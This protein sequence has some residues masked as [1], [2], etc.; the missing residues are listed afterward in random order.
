LDE[1]RYHGLLLRAPELTAAENFYVRKMGLAATS[2]TAGWTRLEDD[3]GHRLYMERVL[4]GPAPAPDQARATV[5]FRVHDIEAAG[6]VFGAA[7]PMPTRQGLCLRIRDPFGNVLS[8]LQPREAAPFREP[9]IHA[10][11]IKIPIAS[12]PGARRLYA[13]TLDFVV[14]DERAYPPLM[15]LCHRDGSPAFTIEDKEIWEP[16]LRVRAPLYPDE[17]GMVLVL[18]TCHAAAQ[19]ERLTRRAPNLKLTPVAEFPLGLRLSFTGI[20]GLAT[21]IWQLAAK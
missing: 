1:L 14:Q 15:A 8:L 9:L 16:D 2:L 21:E 13:D 17:T 7:V 10:A 5:T 3:G 6:R 18:Q 12:V 20:A 19:H 4:P 11:G